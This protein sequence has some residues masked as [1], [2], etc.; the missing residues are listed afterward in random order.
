MDAALTQAGL[1][2]D[3][4]ANA[5]PKPQRHAL[6]VALKGL[7]VPIDGTRGFDWAEVTAG[8]LALDEVEPGSCAVRRYPSLYVIGELLDLQGPIGGLNFQ[9]AFATAE[10]AARACQSHLAARS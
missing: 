4:R 1:A 10:I 8:G 3:V 2:T 9:A 7:R 6:S 5:V